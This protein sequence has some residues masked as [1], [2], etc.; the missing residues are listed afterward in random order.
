MAEHQVHVKEQARRLAHR[1]HEARAEADVGHKVPVHLV[2]VQPFHAQLL[3]TA[4][5]PAKIHQ[6]RAEHGRRNRRHTYLPFHC[7]LI[8]AS[9]SR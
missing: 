9:S 4:K 1:R 5:L 8:G 3:H 2:K 7:S 6:I